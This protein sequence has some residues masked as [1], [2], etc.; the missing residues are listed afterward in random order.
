M[1]TIRVDDIEIQVSH[2]ANIVDDSDTLEF[3][4]G[5]ARAGSDLLLGV[6]VFD[7]PESPLLIYVPN[8]IAWEKVQQ[9]VHHAVD[10]FA[11]NMPDTKLI[12]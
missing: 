12:G 6:T 8:E 3:W 7:R 10:W 9:L 4:R 5:S 11:I 2:T 1:N